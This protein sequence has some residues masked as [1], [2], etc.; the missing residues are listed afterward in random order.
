MC[1]VPP[2]TVCPVT[3]LPSLP[4]CRLSLLDLPRLGWVGLGFDSRGDDKLI[5]SF[6]FFVLFWGDRSVLIYD[7]AK[8]HLV[9]QLKYP[10]S[11][12][13]MTYDADFAIMVSQLTQ[14]RWCCYISACLM[15]DARVMCAVVALITLVPR[16]FVELLTDE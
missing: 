3:W 14:R 11:L 7:L 16:A 5:Q 9:E 4:S 2:L 15:I 1:P 13:N 6:R 8:K 12:M 10:P